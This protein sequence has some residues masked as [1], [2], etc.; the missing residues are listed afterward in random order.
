MFLSFFLC[1]FATSVIGNETLVNGKC[2]IKALRVAMTRSWGLPE[3]I[4][5][6]P[7]KQFLLRN[8]F[9][10]KNLFMVF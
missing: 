4:W 8:I 9:A 1:L 6:S 7:G 5:E 10:K 3:D 2:G